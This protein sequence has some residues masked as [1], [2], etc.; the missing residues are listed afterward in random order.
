[1]A[2]SDTVDEARRHAPTLSDVA[3]RAGVSKMAASLVLNGSRSNTRVSEATRQRI[4]Q[5]AEL[6]GY[7]PNAIARSLSQRQTNIIAVYLEGFIAPRDPFF[8]EILTGL[9]QG[10]HDGRKD[11]LVYGGFR[12]NST[13]D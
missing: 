11:L 13:E 3:Q 7:V 5:A 12:G 10:C 1:R 2:E 9:H 6:L 4:R 8:S